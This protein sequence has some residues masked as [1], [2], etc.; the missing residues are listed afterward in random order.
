MISHNLQTPDHSLPDLP[1]A[2]VFAN[3]LLLT[4]RAAAA[5]AAQA[6]T[7]GM[8][9]ASNLDNL[10]LRATEMTPTLREFD[11]YSHCGINE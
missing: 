3:Q 10:T 11:R 1:M 2:M 8:A 9:S 4:E 7:G 5:A 6:E